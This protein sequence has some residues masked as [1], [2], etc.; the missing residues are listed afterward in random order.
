M[1]A[2]DQA[3]LRN[4]KLTQWQDNFARYIYQETGYVPDLETLKLA[5]LLQK[6]YRVSPWNQSRL[7]QVE[8][9]KPLPDLPFEITSIVTR[10]HAE[11][12][13]VPTVQ[14]WFKIK[15]E[16]GPLFEHRMQEPFETIYTPSNPEPDPAVMAKLQ[17]RI[18]AARKKAGQRKPII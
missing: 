11:P 6:Q 3:S 13:A 4:R 8:V 9:P 12:A 10:S 5:M 18:G 16:M 17:T 7:H 2:P 14:D 1:N 15:K